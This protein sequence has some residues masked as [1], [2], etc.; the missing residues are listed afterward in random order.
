MIRVLTCT[1][2]GQPRDDPPRYISGR[3]VC[4]TCWRRRAP[5]LRYRTPDRA[6]WPRCTWPDAQCDKYA[7][8]TEGGEF[9][10]YCRAHGRMAG[11]L[12]STFERERDRL[13]ARNQRAAEAPTPTMATPKT[14]P[15]GTFRYR[16]RG[17]RYAI[18]YEVV[19]EQVLNRQRWSVKS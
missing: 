6:P 13:A 17:E 1:R 19:T 9:S 18:E 10:H 4:N 8:G 11:D 15:P 14:D 7:Q 3:G 2:C 16:G 5:S 12:R